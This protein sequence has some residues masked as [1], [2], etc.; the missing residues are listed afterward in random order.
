MRKSR[1]FKLSLVFVSILFLQSGFAQDYSRWG[2][3]EGANSRL[4]KGWISGEVAYSP[5]GAL[6][7]VASSIGIW[8]Y[9]AN[10]GAEVYLLS[11][12]TRPALS[13]AFSPDGSALASSAVAGDNTVRLWDIRTG[14]PLKIFEGHANHITSVAFSPD[15]STLAAGDGKNIRLWDVR[16]GERLRTLQGHTS[17]VLSLAFSPDSSTLASGS[18]WN[19]NTVR[20]WNPPHGR[21][22]AIFRGALRRGFNRSH[23]HLMEECSPVAT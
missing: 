6:L 20:L 11:G 14:D 17:L 4:G 12:H 19:D 22:P 13:V 3:P 10:S 8:L 21:A 7:A 23:I 16:T 2:L 18:N 1:F 9:D 5:D 15:G